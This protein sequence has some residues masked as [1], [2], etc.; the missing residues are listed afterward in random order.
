MIN[1]RTIGKYGEDA[2]ACWLAQNGYRIVGRNVY[3]AG[4]EADLLAE[5]Q[6]HFVFVEVKTRS[7]FP[8]APDR[9]GRPADRVN[10]TKKD[11]MLIM[12]KEYLRLHP[13]I[14]EKFSPRLD[15]IEV[16]LHPQTREVL[17]VRHYPGAV[18][19]KGNY[20]RKQAKG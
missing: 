9:F 7:A 14:L 16:Y 1:H 10:T 3:A 8:D 4:M 5:N 20:A 2:A 6:T 17:C 12:A 15:V 11:H 18:R 13:E 19:S